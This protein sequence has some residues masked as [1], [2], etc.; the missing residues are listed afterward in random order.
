MLFKIRFQDLLIE[1]KLPIVI[2]G[3]PYIVVYRLKGQK[4]ENLLIK[5]KLLC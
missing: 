5:R 4:K 3:T 2:Y 1:K